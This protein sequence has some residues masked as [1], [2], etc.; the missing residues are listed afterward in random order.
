MFSI[1]FSPKVVHFLHFKTPPKWK[2]KKD[3]NVVLTKHIATGLKSLY[4]ERFSFVVWIQM[5]TTS[6]SETANSIEST[7]VRGRKIVIFIELEK[8]MIVFVS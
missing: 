5:E 3:K 2:K 6:R 7:F 1:L 8:R 4:V